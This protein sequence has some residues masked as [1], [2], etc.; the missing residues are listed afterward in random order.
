MINVQNHKQKIRI[1]IL[2]QR[3]YNLKYTVKNFTNH[4]PRKVY[5]KRVKHQFGSSKDSFSLYNISTKRIF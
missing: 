4:L 1:E 5:Q 2:S 3:K